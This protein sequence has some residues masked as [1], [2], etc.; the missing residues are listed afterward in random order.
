M[1]AVLNIEINR[2]NK[3]DTILL[4]QISKLING[5]SN[6]NSVETNP[7]KQE[8]TLSTQQ[9]LDKIK[10]LKDQLE[11][12]KKYNSKYKEIIKQYSKSTKSDSK[13]INELE[14]EY[15]KSKEKISELEKGKNTYEVMIEDVQKDSNQKLQEKLNE[16]DRLKNNHK[17]E[18]EQKNAEISK[19]R[20]RLEHYEGPEPTIGETTFYKIVDNRLVKTGVNSAPYI[21]KA[22]E[23]GDWIFHFNKDSGPVKAACSGENPELLKFCEVIERQDDASNIRWG[24]WGLATRNTNGDLTVISNAKIKLTQ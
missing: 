17:T 5:E 21:A 9:L 12:L 18:I 1:K 22:T 6:I 16:I 24:E 4:E 7:T 3:S 8:N 14:E 15:K 2:T 20:K 11:Q 10:E 13:R 19:L 23:N